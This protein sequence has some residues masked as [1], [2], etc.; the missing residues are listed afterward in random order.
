MSSSTTTIF[1]ASEW[2]ETRDLGAKR[3]KIRWLRM[4]AHNTTLRIL[5]GHF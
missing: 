5:T 3:R 1:G 2:A 4:N